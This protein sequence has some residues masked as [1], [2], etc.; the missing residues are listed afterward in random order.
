MSLALASSYLIRGLFFG[1]NTVDGFSI[2]GVSVLF[3][4]IALVAAYPP[5]R[6]ALK[7]DPIVA[8]RAE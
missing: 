5:S 8:L 7:V 4:L 1:L 2:V 6:R 3:L